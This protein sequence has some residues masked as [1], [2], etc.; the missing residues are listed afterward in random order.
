MRILCRWQHLFKR[1]KLTLWVGVLVLFV[2][3]I[4]PWYQL[5]P[6]SLKAFETN[7]FVTN[8]G[9]LLAALLA[10][11]GLAFSLNFIVRRAPRL[12]FLMSLIFTLLFPYFIVIWS[13]TL[14]FLFFF[15]YRHGIKF[16]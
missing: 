2:G 7:L 4:Y 16:C 10:F 13:S 8:V 11:I 12:I 5:P 15:N 14:A 6:Q 3:V 9:R 1:E